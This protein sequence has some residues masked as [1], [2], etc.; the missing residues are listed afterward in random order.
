MAVSFSADFERW[1]YGIGPLHHGHHG[2]MDVQRGSSDRSG[3]IVLTMSSC[4]AISTFVICSNRIKNTATRPAPH[5]LITAEG[6][7]DPPRPSRPSVKRWPCQFWVGC[8]INISEREFSTGTAASTVPI[9][10]AGHHFR[11]SVGRHRFLVTIIASFLFFWA[12]NQ[13]KSLSNSCVRAAFPARLAA[14]SVSK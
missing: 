14:T 7:A 4:L 9:D 1:A 8:T 3:G 2:R 10:A 6:R 13:E 12:D 5:A 11:P